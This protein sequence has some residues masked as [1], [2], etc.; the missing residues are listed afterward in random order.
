MSETAEGVKCGKDLEAIAEREGFI[1]EKSLGQGKFGAVIM[2]RTKA[3]E[4]AVLKKSIAKSRIHEMTH[5]SAVLRIIDD[6]RSKDPGAVGAD[7]LPRQ[8]VDSMGGVV[9]MSYGGMELADYQDMQVC[10][11]KDQTL[12]PTKYL[13]NTQKVARDLFAAVH[14]LSVKCRMCHHDIKHFNVAV[15][16]KGQGGVPVAQ[17]FDFGTCYPC[18]F[19]PDDVFGTNAYHPY[20]VHIDPQYYRPTTETVNEIADFF[21]PLSHMYNGEA[22]GMLRCKDPARIDEPMGSCDTFGVAVMLCELLYG[23]QERV[24]G[25]A[26]KAFEHMLFPMGNWA[27]D[28]KKTIV[29]SVD[30]A[31]R[32]ESEALQKLHEKIMERCEEPEL[33]QGIIDTALFDMGAGN[34]ILRGLTK[35]PKERITALEAYNHPFFST[36]VPNIKAGQREAQVEGGYENR[37]GYKVGGVTPSKAEYSPVTTAVQQE[38]Q[39]RHYS[40]SSPQLGA[41]N[42]QPRDALRRSSYELNDRRTSYGR[43]SSDWDLPSPTASSPPKEDLLPSLDEIP[44]TSGDVAWAYCSPKKPLAEGDIIQVSIKGRWLAAKVVVVTK[45]RKG[46]DYDVKYDVPRFGEEGGVPMARIRYDPDKV[47]LK[48]PGGS[49]PKAR[50]A[51]GF[52]EPEVPVSQ[53]VSRRTRA[54]APLSSEAPRPASASPP[55]PAWTPAT[56]L[57]SPEAKVLMEKIANLNDSQARKHSNQRAL[58]LREAEAELREL[59]LGGNSGASRPTPAAAKAASVTARAATTPTYESH[60]TSNAYGSASSS[61]YGSAYGR[62][63]SAAAQKAPEVDPTPIT[64]RFRR[65]A[66]QAATASATSASSSTRYQADPAPSRYRP[67]S[68]AATTSRYQPASRTTEAPASARYSSYN[69]AESLQ[70]YDP[71]RRFSARPASATSSAAAPSYV[72]SSTASSAYSSTARTSHGSRALE[73]EILDLAGSGSRAGRRSSRQEDPAD[74][75]EQLSELRSAQA[76]R[77]NAERHKQVL[78]LESKLRDMGAAP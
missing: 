78:L 3:G 30:L 16:P 41:A 29:D 54:P 51:H 42:S 10:G 1:F 18:Q 38:Q 63:A 77:H 39:P 49:L 32:S 11:V 8:L 14:F 7:N 68:Q 60:S 23:I 12:T 58:L 66:E 22:Q 52:D 46:Y 57:E 19:V 71:V 73:Q 45:N 43:D 70:Q 21:E 13:A 36:K 65:E 75:K 72:S 9:C 69:P 15:E 27:Q 31:Q 24:D 56:D 76:R 28:Y 25:G 20:E 44:D 50:E 17:L 62:Q 37:G 64:T 34:L 74:L 48:P 59:Q 33:F 55:E 47:V 40:L 4:R 67:A 26:R 35:S 5:E 2:V 61:A 6:E 53:V